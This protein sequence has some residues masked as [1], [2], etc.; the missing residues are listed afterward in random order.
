MLLDVEK[1][2]YCADVDNWANIFKELFR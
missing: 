2:D 1:G